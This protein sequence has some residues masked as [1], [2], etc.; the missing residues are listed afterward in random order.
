MTNARS[1]VPPKRSEWD[2]AYAAVRAALSALNLV[3][4]LAHRTR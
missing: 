2:Y 4:A 3:W 1:L